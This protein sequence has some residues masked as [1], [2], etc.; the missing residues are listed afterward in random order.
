MSNVAKK[1]K[2]ERNK[3]LK[4]DLKNIGCSLLHLTAGNLSSSIDTIKLF[5]QSA[6]RFQR[7]QRLIE[8]INKVS[9]NNPE[10]KI[11]LFNI[12]KDYE[13]IDNEMIISIICKTI[14][15][16]NV[17]KR[18]LL[19]KI[20]LFFINNNEFNELHETLFNN[21]N[22]FISQDFKNI[23]ILK[24]QIDNSI[25]VKEL[26]GYYKFNVQEN[27]LTLLNTILKLI[28]I[29]IFQETGVAVLSSGKPQKYR[30]NV[31][32]YIPNDNFSTLAQYLL[33]II[34]KYIPQDF[35][36]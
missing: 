17:I 26:N 1:L 14:E 21:L 5:T 22:F 8:L 25:I 33:E 15:E 23:L 20:M 28:N 11:T 34:E 36:N 18:N 2:K 32:F 19:A 24:K 10:A 31:L 35:K 6:S 3:N 4:S 30:E 27:N 13:N 7:E 9:E 16:S 12:L 29:Q